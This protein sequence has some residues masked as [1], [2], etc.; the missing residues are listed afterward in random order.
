ML[1]EVRSETHEGEKLVYPR[2][3]SLFLSRLMLT[4]TIADQIVCLLALST[5]RQSLASPPSLFT[6]L[7]G[8]ALRRGERRIVQVA[9][10]D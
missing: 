7:H 6:R 9:F 2:L 4:D 8:Q 1:S 10:E 3:S 5:P